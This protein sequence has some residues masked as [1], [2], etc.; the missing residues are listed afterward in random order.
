MKSINYNKEDLKN[1]SAIGAVILDKDRR[2]LMQYHN[3][4]NFWTIPIGKVK[5]NQTINEGLKE[6]LKEECNMEVTDFKQIK[7]RRYEYIRNGKKVKVTGYLFI[8]NK[9]KGTIKNNEPKKHRE[10]IFL[11]LDE[12]LNKRYLSDLTLLYLEYMG[13][14]RKAIL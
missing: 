6:E 13:Y 8:I 14:K 4:Y 12:I 3:K 5:Y 10:L 2:I 7:H 9:Y 11:S 1:H